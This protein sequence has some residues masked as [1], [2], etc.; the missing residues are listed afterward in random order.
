[1]IFAICSADWRESDYLLVFFTG[2]GGKNQ[3]H[4]DID[5]NIELIHI[6]G[7]GNA[8]TLVTFNQGNL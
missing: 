6:R 8:T 4:R 7:T 1:M 3:R 2:L 5:W